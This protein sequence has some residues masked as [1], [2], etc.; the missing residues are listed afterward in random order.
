[1][2]FEWA[3]TATLFVLV[4]TENVV[5]TQAQCKIHTDTAARLAAIIFLPQTFCVGCAQRNGKKRSMSLS[6]LLLPCA[7]AISGYTVHPWI[8]NFNKK[9]YLYIS[10]VSTSFICDVIRYRVKLLKRILYF[11]IFLPFSRA[12]WFRSFAFR[13]GILNYMV[14]TGVG[15]TRW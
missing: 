8:S 4:C 14:L 2:F 7:Y 3:A 11:D 13:S 6:S 1:M 10:L 9:K 12:F 15:L 5:K